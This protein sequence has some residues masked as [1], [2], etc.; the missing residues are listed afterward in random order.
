MGVATE[1]FINAAIAGAISNCKT[2]SREEIGCGAFF[3]TI[4]AGWS[5]GFRCGRENIIVAENKLADAERRA[6]RREIELGSNYVP[7]MPRCARVVTVDPN[8]AIVVSKAG[9]S[10]PISTFR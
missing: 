1:S 6:V 10:I 5:L 8:G 4:Q 2:L 9:Y 7:D 3:T